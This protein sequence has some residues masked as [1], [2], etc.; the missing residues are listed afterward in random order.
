MHKEE[1]SAYL[2]IP[3]IY[4]KRRR[5]LLENVLRRFDIHGINTRVF[6]ESDLVGLRFDRKR[7]NSD[8]LLSILQL[9]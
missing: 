1:S 3:Y 7:E 2:Q 6:F 5:R 9:D 8:S 4:Q